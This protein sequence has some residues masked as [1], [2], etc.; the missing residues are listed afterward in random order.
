MTYTNNDIFG[1]NK[2]LIYNFFPFLCITILG[3]IAL[4]FSGAFIAFIFKNQ[5][6]FIKIIIFWQVHQ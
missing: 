5:H 3:E 2:G 6:V 1:Q 4:K